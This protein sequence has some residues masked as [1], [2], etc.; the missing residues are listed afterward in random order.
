MFSSDSLVEK[1]KATW[2]QNATVSTI[3]TSSADDQPSSWCPHRTT[4]TVTWKSHTLKNPSIESQ[5]W[6]RTS[7]WA[8]SVHVRG[9]HVLA[10]RVQQSSRQALDVIKAELSERALIVLR[11]K[12]NTVT[13]TKPTKK[14][15]QIQLYLWCDPQ[16][17]ISAIRKANILLNNSSACR[18]DEVNNNNIFITQIL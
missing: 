7:S 9:V 5:A 17:S 18:T 6:Q 2:L 3:S 16:I 15:L 1:R 8:A 4:D 13:N 11:G 14:R 10:I 12:L